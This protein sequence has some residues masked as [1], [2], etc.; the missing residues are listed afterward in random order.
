MNQ[1]HAR[2]SQ[3]SLSRG[4]SPYQPPGT[5]FTTLDTA[6]HPLIY[7]PQTDTKISDTLGTRIG[8]MYQTHNS[9]PGHPRELKLCRYTPRT[10]TNR[11]QVI[12]GRFGR[13]KIF[14]HF[15]SFRSFHEPG[16]RQDVLRVPGLKPWTIL[17]AS[18]HAMV[19]LT[20]LTSKS[21]VPILIQISDSSTDS[22]MARA[23][24]DI[25]EVQAF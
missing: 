6:F 15:C 12:P 18:N 20:V 11:F 3:E 2:T 25:L 14:V 9:P 23:P 7:C 8:T 10:D 4:H 17:K 13:F 1:E 21:T 5:G 16:T 24:N 22:Q 19:I